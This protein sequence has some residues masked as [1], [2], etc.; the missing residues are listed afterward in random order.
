MSERSQHSRD[1]E[2]LRR[3]ANTHDEG[4]KNSKKQA[5][6]VSGGKN[7]KLGECSFV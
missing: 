4:D 3:E 6:A 7:Q 5:E 1:S 2:H